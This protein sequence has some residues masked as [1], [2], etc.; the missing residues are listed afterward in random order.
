MPIREYKCSY[1]DYKFEELQKLNDLP[2]TY[3]P[4]C[5]CDIV[6]LK[7]Q[8]YTVVYKC[9][10]FYTTD[11]RGITGKKRKPNIKVGLVSDLPPREQE[12]AREFL[13]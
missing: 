4:K 11:Q 2:L 6:E 9:A 13:V 1:C 12:K 10:G 7:F 8:P 3:C 5:G